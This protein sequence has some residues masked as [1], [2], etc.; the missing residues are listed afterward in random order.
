MCQLRLVLVW[1]LFGMQQLELG[2]QQ[3]ELE[4]IE[5]DYSS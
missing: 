2:M 1:F 3:L 5:Y 4:R